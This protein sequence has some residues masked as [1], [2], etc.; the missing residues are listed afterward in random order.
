MVSKTFFF[1]SKVMVHSREGKKGTDRCFSL[2]LTP[3]PSRAPSP[4]DN[5]TALVEGRS[6]AGILQKELAKL[7]RNHGVMSLTSG[8]CG[9]IGHWRQPCL[10]S[11]GS[12]RVRQEAHHGQPLHRLTMPPAG[13]GEPNIYKGA[14]RLPGSP[15]LL[16]VGWFALSSNRFMCVWHSVS[17]IK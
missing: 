4:H 10:L 12:A 8:P 13:P 15:V 6:K 11:A 2:A 3:C 5:D 14:P 16:K 7:N 1:F 9:R 17:D